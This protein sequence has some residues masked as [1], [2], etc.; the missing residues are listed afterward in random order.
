MHNVIWACMCICIYLFRLNSKW[1]II[2]NLKSDLLY[3]NFNKY[4]SKS[5]TVCTTVFFPCDIVNNRWRVLK[6]TN[7]IHNLNNYVRIERRNLSM[8]PQYPLR[9]LIG[10]SIYIPIGLLVSASILHLRAAYW[11]KYF[12]RFLISNDT[13]QHDAVMQVCKSYVGMGKNGY[14]FND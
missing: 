4:K 9:K 6:I 7:L 10:W 12:S 3:I 1:S 8:C 13:K 2:R 14:D 5:K 11:I